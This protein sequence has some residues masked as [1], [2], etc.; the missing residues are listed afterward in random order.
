LVE[1][2]ITKMELVDKKIKDNGNR[3]IQDRIIIKQTKEKSH[4]KRQEAQEEKNK[5]N[6]LLRR[7]R[8]KFYS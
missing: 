8:N 3:I 1:K 7:R 6:S 5:I 4:H 2:K